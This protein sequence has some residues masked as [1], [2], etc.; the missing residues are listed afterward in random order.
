MNKLFIA[1]FIV[2]V[3]LVCNTAYATDDYTIELEILNEANTSGEIIVIN[4]DDIEIQFT[5]S[6]P[7]GELSKD[8][9]I[10]IRDLYTDKILQKKKRGKLDSM[11][12][13]NISLKTKKGKQNNQGSSHIIVE[14]QSKHHDHTVLS[15]STM[16]VMVVADQIAVELLERVAALE[17]A[18]PVPG[19]VGPA[20]A[21]GAQGPAGADGAQGPAGADGTQGPAGADGT[22]GPA[23]ADGTQGPAGADGTQGPAGADGTQ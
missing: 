9:V 5:V 20:G 7:S 15:T 16:T 22:Q 8:D 1:I 4:G 11:G 10:Q 17:A 23:G 6:D 2:V 19:P 12:V 18:D 3:T 13:G 14:Y 21:D